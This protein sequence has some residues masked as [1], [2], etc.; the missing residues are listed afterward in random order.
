MFG[1]RTQLWWD[2]AVIESFN[3]LSKIYE[4]PVNEYKEKLEILNSIFKLEE[5]LHTPV[6]KLSSWP[7]NEM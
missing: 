2:I 6:R 4:V 5:L 7:K 1:Q 3:L